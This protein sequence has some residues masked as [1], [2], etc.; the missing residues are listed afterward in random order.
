[1]RNT[2]THTHTHT[3]TEAYLNIL[4]LQMPPHIPH[5]SAASLATPACLCRQWPEAHSTRTARP[6]PCS[7]RPSRWPHAAAGAVASR[8]CGGG[9]R[10][11]SSRYRPGRLR[12]RR[13]PKRRELCGRR[14]LRRRRTPARRELPKQIAR[15]E[16]RPR[17]TPARREL[18]RRRTPARRQRRRWRPP[19]GDL[20]W[21]FPPRGALY[22]AA[23]RTGGRH[24]AAVP[25]QMEGLVQRQTLEKD[26]GR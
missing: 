2:I 22:P 19:W 16:V 13:I 6:L 15:R 24:L 7:P 26:R 8:T 21:R 4:Y 10:T 18:R 3:H 20:W 14:E 25:K 12:R 17:R 23:L 5:C 9:Q 1:M 11:R